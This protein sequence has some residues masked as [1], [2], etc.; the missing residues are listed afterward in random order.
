MGEGR[1]TTRVRRVVAREVLLLYGIAGGAVLL[2]LGSGFI[3]V[4]FMWQTYVISFGVLYSF[5]LLAFGIQTLR[6]RRGGT[7]SDVGQA[8]LVGPGG[9]GQQSRE[10]ANDG[11]AP[12]FEQGTLSPREVD[13]LRLLDAG[14]GTRA[15][16]KRLFLSQS[17]VRNHINSIMSKLDS[18]SRVEALAEARRR[19]LL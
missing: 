4:R 11:D 7:G 19:R 16:G 1:G 14:L 17:T 18:H 12:P 10:S 9:A 8:P 3:G 2:L 5:R 13:V 15:I 6:E